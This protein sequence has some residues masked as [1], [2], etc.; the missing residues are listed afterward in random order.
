MPCRVQPAEQML[1]DASVAE[2]GAG[3]P[4]AVLGRLA[5]CDAVPVVSAIAGDGVWRRS[6]AAVSCLAWLLGFRTARMLIRRATRQVFAGEVIYDHQNMERRP[7][8]RMSD[9]KSAQR[10]FGAC[11]RA[12]G[13][14]LFSHVWRKIE[15][16]IFSATMIVGIFVFALGQNGMTEASATRVVDRVDTAIGAGD[17]ARIVGG[18]HAACGCW[19]PVPGYGCTSPG[20]DR[21]RP[22]RRAAASRDETVYQAAASKAGPSIGGR[23][24]T[25]IQAR[26]LADP[27]GARIPARRERIDR[28]IQ[29]F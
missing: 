28:N 8:A 23:G 3:S 27:L 11:G 5:W 15:S 1:V 4:R 2:L 22:S 14:V 25:I 13:P 29:R 26:N 21:R 6:S 10:W 16:A 19:V 17:A 20:H 7:S 24:D 12:I 18:A 9:T